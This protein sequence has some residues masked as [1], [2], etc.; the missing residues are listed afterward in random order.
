VNVD[1]DRAVV[2]TD[3]P[4]VVALIRATVANA[5]SVVPLRSE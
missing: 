2:Y 5:D 1:E 4:E 3:A